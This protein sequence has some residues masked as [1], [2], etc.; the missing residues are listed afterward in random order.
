MKI[1]TVL[2][3]SQY[4]ILKWAIKVVG[5]YSFENTKLDLIYY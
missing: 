4:L 3:D 2:K 5:C 1:K